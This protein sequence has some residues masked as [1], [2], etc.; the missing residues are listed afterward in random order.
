[1]MIFGVCFVLYYICLYCSFFHS[2]IQLRS[3][4]LEFNNYCVAFFT[5]WCTSISNSP[6]GYITSPYYPAMYLNNMNR[7]WEIEVLPGQRLKF[8][9][10]YINL[11]D[12]KT[13]KKDSLVF[14]GSRSWTRMSFCGNKLPKSFF[15]QGNKA[16]VVFKSDKRNV[17]TGFKL[18]Y[19]AVPGK[20][21]KESLMSIHENIVSICSLH[22]VSR[23][24]ILL[25]TIC[26]LCAVLHRDTLI[27]FW[28]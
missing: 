10:L 12:D 27:N 19:Q 1:M 21:E 20:C 26:L 17:G 13:C 8:D 23:E 16:V 7:C 4:F 18:R 14:K 22:V 25:F 11:E 9:W 28:V 3:L 15:T 2:R 5:E 6:S 24:C